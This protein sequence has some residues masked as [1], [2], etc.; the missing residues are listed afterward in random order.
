MALRFDQQTVAVTGSGRG[1]GRS[2]ALFFAS[3]GANVLINDTGAQTTR[4]DLVPDPEKTISVAETT[5]N[6]INSNGTAKSGF[7]TV[8]AEFGDAVVR[9]ALI[10]F[11]RL[12]VL[13]VNAGILRSAR[14]ER[15]SE[16]AFDA[17]WRVNVKGAYS[18]IR[19]AWPVFLKQG[20][21][22]IVLTSSTSGTFGSF[23]GTNY[24]SSKNALI[25]FLLSISSLIESLPG[26]PDI[27]ISAVCPFAFTRMSSTVMREQP[28]PE[29][30]SPD[31]V[32]PV[33][34][35][36][37][38]KEYGKACNGD[39]WLAG[40]GH[41]GSGGNSHR[42]LATRLGGSGLGN[43]VVQVVVNDGKWSEDKMVDGVEKQLS[44]EVDLCIFD[45]SDAALS[46]PYPLPFTHSSVPDTDLDAS[47][48]YLTS[49]HR[50]Y[51]LPTLKIAQ[52][53]YARMRRKERP[54]G[55]FVSFVRA[56]I[57]RE[58]AR[59]AD[60]RMVVGPEWNSA[61]FAIHALLQVLTVESQYFSFDITGHTV[62]LH[63]VQL[64]DTG[65]VRPAACLAVVAELMGERGGET[66][67][68]CIFN[69]FPLAWRASP[70]SQLSIPPPFSVAPYPSQFSQFRTDDVIEELQNGWKVASNVYADGSYWPKSEPEAAAPAIAHV[71]QWL[72]RWFPNY[73][74]E[75]VLGVH[76][77]KGKFE[78]NVPKNSRL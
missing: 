53:V 41:Y 73:V 37:A 4:G 15:M 57:G 54:N 25:G 44:G 34:A 22:R 19:A 71:N 48:D 62:A 45:Y 31:N 52:F 21:G 28:S 2:H 55:R 74:P 3:R 11:G 17:M 46:S 26:D 64:G 63:P 42:E 59:T 13:V 56:D 77:K 69:G 70:G 66:A 40:Y 29:G 24:G 30:L 1:L 36:L 12:D 32:A 27:S 58:G 18:A 43:R 51:L 47:L 72:A 49:L 60:G 20:Y 50:S 6:F 38:S 67:K 5:S 8:S 7:T 16:S 10:Q 65:G 78:E 75:D 39:V 9:Q 23:G 14:L 33:V 68:M 61:A 76:G 35:M